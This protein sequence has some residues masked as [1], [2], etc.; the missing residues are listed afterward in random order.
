MGGAPSGGSA[1][2][3]GGIGSSSAC[4]SSYGDGD[5]ERPSDAY[6]WGPPRQRPRGA[7]VS[8]TGQLKP[9][10]VPHFPLPNAPSPVLDEV[11]DDAIG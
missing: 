6:A 10:S 2:A 9:W 7:Y 11:L 4:W 3:S 8:H 1:V 5:N